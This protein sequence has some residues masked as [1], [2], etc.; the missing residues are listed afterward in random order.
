MKVEKGL[1]HF[2]CF[3]KKHFI[4]PWPKV[5]SFAPGNNQKS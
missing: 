3:I 5:K 4:F 2:V 1:L